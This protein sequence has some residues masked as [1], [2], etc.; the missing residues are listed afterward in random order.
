MLKLGWD[1]VFTII[2]L[3]IL[4]FLM[5]KFLFKPVMGIMEERE[6]LIG[7]QLKNAKDA[8]DKAKELKATWEE[9]V[10]D[11]AKEKE[12]IIL[13]AKTRAKAEADKIVADANIQAKSI[14][15]NA[16]KLVEAD[17]EKA[18]KEIESQVAQIAM[19]AAAKI[20]NDKT[21]EINNSA[22][23]DEFLADNSK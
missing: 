22:I 4:Y 23:Y 14:V 3:L 1:L 6:K 20:V 8:E 10:A 15:E 21:N 17:K 11:T 9:S 19:I 5:R 16:N 12:K 7:D 2:N 18:V 13:D